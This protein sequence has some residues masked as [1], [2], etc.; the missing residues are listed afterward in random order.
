MKTK[1][2]KKWEKV[3]LNKWKQGKKK[4]VEKWEEIR[5]TNRQGKSDQIL[6]KQTKNKTQSGP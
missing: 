4:K 3:K 1:K 6:N 5:F 2:L